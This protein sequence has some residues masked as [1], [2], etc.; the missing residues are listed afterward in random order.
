[1][2]KTLQS[3]FL[4]NIRA[5]SR[6][7]PDTTTWSGGEVAAGIVEDRSPGAEFPDAVGA[8]K[9]ISPVTVQWSF[10]PVVFSDQV[11]SELFA[12]VGKDN[13]ITATRKPKDANGNPYGKGRTYVGTLSAVRE[14]DTD[15][16][17]G[18]RAPFEVEF[19]PSSVT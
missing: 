3:G 1:M 12:L 14:P 13:A 6:G 2:A 17:T 19:Q 18:D 10:D 16:T 11:I 8:L 5:G 7:L 9:T 4:T 15:A